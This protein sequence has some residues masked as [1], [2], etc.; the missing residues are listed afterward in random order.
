MHPAIKET[1]TGEEE[2]LDSGW[3]T[4]LAAAKAADPNF[5]DYG[6]K[7]LAA[8][9]ARLRNKIT[10][11]MKHATG[12]P[13][14]ELFKI[15]YMLSVVQE[16]TTYTLDDLAR[17]VPG[18]WVMPTGDLDLVDRVR[19]IMSLSCNFAEDL[20]QSG[21]QDFVNHVDKPIEVQG[22]LKRLDRVRTHPQ[23]LSCAPTLSVLEVK[24]VL[25]AEIWCTWAYENRSPLPSEVAF[26]DLFGRETAAK[27]T[28]F[29]TQLAEAFTCGEIRDY[30]IR[31]YGFDVAI[32]RSI[33]ALFDLVDGCDESM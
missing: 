17:V 22:F 14:E 28:E 8:D 9:Y 5:E 3:P 4:F 30:I 6:V 32:L 21:F 19:D 25:C 12:H 31:W 18:N 11:A 20:S 16:R 10:Q 2:G 33:S 15:G 24:A 27:I 7:R 26:I 1:P 23:D 13:S 29:A